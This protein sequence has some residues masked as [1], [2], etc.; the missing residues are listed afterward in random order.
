MTI[1]ELRDLAGLVLRLYGE[2]E[3]E[4]DAESMT[5]VK[6]GHSVRRES[7]VKKKISA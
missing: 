4:E 6:R 5:H 2:G 7:G 3:E 1:E